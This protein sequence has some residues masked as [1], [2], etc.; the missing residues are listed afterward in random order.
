VDSQP[1]L[2]CGG[3]E[4]RVLGNRLGA[5]VEAEETGDDLL[6]LLGDEP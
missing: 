6:S 4:F 5:S 2:W 3:E 1:Y